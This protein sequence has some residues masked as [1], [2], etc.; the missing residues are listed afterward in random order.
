MSL[1]LT[2]EEREL[3]IDV[4]VARLGELRQEIHHSTVS[5]F[6]DQLKQTEV[7]MKALI[8]KI[9]ADKAGVSGN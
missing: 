7:L 8:D 6:T 3:L 1:E 2:Q 4:L 5:T 9:K